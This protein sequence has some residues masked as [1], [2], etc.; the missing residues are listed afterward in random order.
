MDTQ[1]QIQEA[2]V[3]V[4]VD[5]TESLPLEVQLKAMTKRQLIEYGGNLGFNIDRRLKEST[6]IQNILAVVADR[7]SNAAKTN[8][9]SLRAT[10]TE[11]DPMIEVRFF[12]IET[13]GVDIEFAFAGKKGMYGPKYIKDGKTYGN[14]KGHRKCPKYHLF[15]GEVTKVAYSV[16]EHLESLT[17]VTHKTVFDPVSGM[18]QGNIPIVKPRFIL[19]PVVTKSDLININ[20]NR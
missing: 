13:P 14:P 6:I 9:E 3:P 7:K 16:Y 17:F 2:R 12:N 15:P 11:D 8:A 18:I 20:K 5:V 4:Q 10:V 19:Q 1:E